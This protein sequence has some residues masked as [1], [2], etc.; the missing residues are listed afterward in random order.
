MIYDYLFKYVV[1]GDAGIGKSCLVQRY[2]ENKFNTIHDMTIGVEFGVKTEV[3]EMNGIDIKIKSQIWDTAG[4]EVF[5]A[6]TKNYYRNCAGVLLCYDPNNRKSFNRLD[7]WIKDI[8]TL[9]P[10]NVSVMLVS[11]KNDVSDKPGK[12]KTC[13]GEK[14]AEENGFLFIETSSKLN[15]NVKESFRTLGYKILKD[16]KDGI[17]EIDDYEG[18]VKLP[19]PLLP[20]KEKTSCC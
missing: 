11:T 14:L 1:I 13:E 6:I 3:I 18:G 9:C 15:N 17:F 19:N 5:N 10:K 12:V 8:K 16:I 2:T 20:K 7:R 4:Q